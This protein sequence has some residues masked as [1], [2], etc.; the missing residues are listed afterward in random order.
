MLCEY[1]WAYIY[2]PI[3]TDNNQNNDNKTEDD[4]TGNKKE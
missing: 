2:T 1:M 4:L 3:H